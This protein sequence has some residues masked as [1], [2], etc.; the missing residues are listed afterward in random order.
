MPSVSATTTDGHIAHANGPHSNAAKVDP[1]QVKTTDAHATHINTTHS[2][3]ANG[4]TSTADGSK[5]DFSKTRVC[6]QVSLPSK[7]K[8]VGT[9]FSGPGL[10]ALDNRKLW[11]NGS[12]LSVKIIG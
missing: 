10:E 4:S 1:T 8:V 7:Q 9:Q 6:A 3:D 11:P 2:H 5:V 12:T